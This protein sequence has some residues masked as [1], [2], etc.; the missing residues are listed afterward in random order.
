MKATKSLVFVSLLVIVTMLLGACAAPA[1][2]TVE[3]VVTQ[4]VEK[5]NRS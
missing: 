5:R 2:Q 1:P 4:I 3:K